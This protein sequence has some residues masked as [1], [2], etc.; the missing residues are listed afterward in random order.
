MFIAMECPV[1]YCIV[2]LLLKNIEKIFTTYL[3]AKRL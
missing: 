3:C 1:F 2:V